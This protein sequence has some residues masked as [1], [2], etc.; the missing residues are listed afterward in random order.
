METLTINASKAALT[1]AQ[2]YNICRQN[3]GLRFE[4]TAQ[5]DLIVMPP[6]GGLSGSRESDLNADVQIW[7]RRTGLGQVFSSSTVFQ[8]PNGAKRSPDVAWVEQSRWDTLSREA[9]EKFPPLAPDFVIE[10]RSRTDDLAVL[11]AKMQ[12]YVENGVRLGWLINP[13]DQQVEIYQPGK[14]K[15]M[16][17][18]PTQLSGEEILPGFTLDLPQF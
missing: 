4:M 6:V 2:F 10:L 16:T 13:Q 18:L 3:E 7:N 8:L 1:E 14:D 11:Q 15:E 12:E 17:S 9:Q 5:G